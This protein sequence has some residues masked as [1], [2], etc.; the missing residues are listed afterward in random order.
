MTKPNFIKVCVCM[1]ARVFVV[2]CV[3]SYGMCVC[4]CVVCLVDSDMLDNTE[5]SEYI[6]RPWSQTRHTIVV[7]RKKEKLEESLTQ[8]TKSPKGVTFYGGENS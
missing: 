2:V 4:V 3:Y 8:T 5:Y 6:S 1:R 7:Q